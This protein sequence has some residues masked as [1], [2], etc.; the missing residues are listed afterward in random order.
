MSISIS[1]KL[2]I[3]EEIDKR[4]KKHEEEW[5]NERHC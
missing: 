4:N 5:K 2:K 1:K 3:M